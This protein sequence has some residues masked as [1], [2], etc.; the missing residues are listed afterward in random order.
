MKITTDGKNFDLPI[1]LPFST[2]IVI[3]RDVYSFA[4]IP[5]PEELLSDGE[6]SNGFYAGNIPIY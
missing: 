3:F 6:W 4:L 5:D 2:K 1:R